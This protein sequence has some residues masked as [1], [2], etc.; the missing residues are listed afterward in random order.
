MRICDGKGQPD[1]IEKIEKLLEVLENGSL[2]G[3][4]KSAPNPVRSTLTHFRSEYLAHI[5]DHKCPAGVCR[6]L[7]SYTITD[8]CTGCRRC[9]KVCPQKAISGNKKELH[10]IDQDLCNRCGICKATCKFDAV[11]IVS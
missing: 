4:G 5:E 2:C 7:I 11:K 10:Q 3:L 1:D 6:S 9:A 8:H